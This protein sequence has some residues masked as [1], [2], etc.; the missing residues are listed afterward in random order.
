MRREKSSEDNEFKKLMERFREDEDAGCPD[1]L[2]AEICAELDF[3]GWYLR[4]EPDRGPTYVDGI[5]ERWF[6]EKKR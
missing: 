5:I 6:R 3:S 4:G 2:A 1:L